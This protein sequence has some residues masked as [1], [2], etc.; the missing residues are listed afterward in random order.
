MI[1]A[2]LTVLMDVKA[3]CLMMLRIVELV[4]LSVLS[5]NVNKMQPAQM[6]YVEPLQK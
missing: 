3:T 5:M 1:I 6:V 4:L 2:I